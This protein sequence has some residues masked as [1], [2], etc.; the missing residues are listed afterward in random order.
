VQLQQVILNLAMNG[1]EAMSSVADRPRHFLVCSRRH[2]SDHVLVTLQ[3]FGIGVA[4][5]SLKKI[6]IAFYT[7]KSQGIG[8]GLAIARSIIENHG[9]RLWAVPNDGPGMTFQFALPVQA[10]RATSTPA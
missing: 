9:G 6:F 1:I 3:D 7:T 5:E 4:P 2:G 10:A 8:M